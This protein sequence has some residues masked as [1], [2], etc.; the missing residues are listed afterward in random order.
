MKNPFTRLFVAM[1][2]LVA[3]VITIGFAATWMFAKFTGDIGVAPIFPFQVI[4]MALGVVGGIAFM[5]AAP[6]PR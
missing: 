3:W 2:A 5:L 6:T 4:V 1:V